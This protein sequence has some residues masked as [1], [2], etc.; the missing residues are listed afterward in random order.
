MEIRICKTEQELRELARLADEIWHEYFVELLSLE[1]IDYMV[2]KYQSENALEHAIKSEGYLYYLLYNDNQLVGY[3]GIKPEEN[4]IFLSKL[5]LQKSQRGKGLASLL[6]NQVIQYAKSNGKESIY[7]T[8]NK[9]NQHSLDVYAAKG[10]Y[11]IDA[12]E[13]DI[14][15]GFIM[16]DYVLQLDVQ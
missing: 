12:V 15:H 9:H 2:E 13:T 1:Q 8:C 6:L 16:D 11:Q 7:L 5:Y 10:F 3:C 14:G 4:R